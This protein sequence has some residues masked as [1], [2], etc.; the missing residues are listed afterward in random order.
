MSSII[1]LSYNFDLLTYFVRFII[2]LDVES[3]KLCVVVNQ[4]LATGKMADDD[5]FSLDTNLDHVCMCLSLLYH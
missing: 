2:K 1:L 5:D 3:G 4:C